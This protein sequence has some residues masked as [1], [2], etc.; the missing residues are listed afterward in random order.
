MKKIGFLPNITRDAN[1][2]ATCDLM[3]FAADLGY[4]VASLSEYSQFLPSYCELMDST[5]E[6]CQISDFIVTLGGDGTVLKAAS[7]AA[8][9][10]TPLLGINLGNVGYLTDA[11]RANAKES[12]TKVVKGNYKIQERMMLQVS[13]GGDSPSLALNDVTINRGLSSRLIQCVVHINGEYMDTF[14]ADGI[15]I[16]TPTGSTAYNLAAGGPIVR[17]DAKMVVITPISPHSL[18]TRPAVIS[19]EDIVSI[20][21]VNNHDIVVSADGEAI[22][23]PTAPDYHDGETEILIS[24]AKYSTHIIKTNSFGFYE[25]LRMKFS[26]SH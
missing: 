24:Q 17:P 10:A 2:Y 26:K 19:H 8:L 9:T 18:S 22:S 4:Q 16:S 7:Y 5:N 12:I 6:L 1:L 25:I 23:L 15:I 3:G 13:H 21:F 14:R 11:E 20:R